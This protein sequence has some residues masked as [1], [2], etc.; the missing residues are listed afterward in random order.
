MRSEFMA[1]AQ[2][3]SGY[4]VAVDKLLVAA[5]AAQVD[6]TSW[7]LIVEKQT[8]AMD[9]KTYAKRSRQD[10]CRL[11]QIA[12]LRQQAQLLGRYFGLL[13]S[14]ATSDAPD[15][16]K[17]AIEGV[18]AGLAKLKNELPAAATA[19]PDVGR[20]V[21]DLK[22]RAALREELH[23]RQEIIREHLRIQEQLLKELAD[24]VKHALEISKDSQ[25]QTLILD[26]IVSSKG[27]RSP[28]NWVSTRRRILLTPLTIAE[29]E[30]A[31]HSAAKLR[32]A[33]EGLIT[34]EVTAGRM[35]AVLTDIEGLLSI[36]ETIGS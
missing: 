2:A 27:L 34:G 33:F 35:N 16:T 11:E 23:S 25:E 9:E 30:A 32:E 22:I 26:P 1:F 10:L 17:T 21:V 36:A 15:R 14:L 29:L 13:E 6:S 3:G 20:V 24:Q 8:T 18:V 4:A 5:G 7:T 12:R 19:L 31:S 28:E